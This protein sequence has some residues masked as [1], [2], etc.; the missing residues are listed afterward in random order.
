MFIALPRVSIPPANSVA[1]ATKSDVCSLRIAVAPPRAFS[2]VAMLPESSSVFE[3]EAS[4]SPAFLNRPVSI[5]KPLFLVVF[6]QQL[7]YS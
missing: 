6:A 4:A 2:P 7:L 3:L 5:S 1:V